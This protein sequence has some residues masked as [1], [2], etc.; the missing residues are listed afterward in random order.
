MTCVQP[1]FTPL[2]FEPILD[3]DKNSILTTVSD[4]LCAGG[5]MARPADTISCNDNIDCPV[6][7][8]GL[9]WG[10][11]PCYFFSPTVI[12]RHACIT[13]KT[14]MK[15]PYPREKGPMGGV[16]Y[17]GPRLHGDARWANIRSITVV[18]NDKRVPR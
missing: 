12:N 11:V 18:V 10:E 1:S 16:P 8:R 3:K 13:S 17:F 2:T 6:R 7:W 4:S 9:P 15:L 14:I 5:S